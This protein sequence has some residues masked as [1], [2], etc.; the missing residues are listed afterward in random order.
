MQA[1]TIYPGDR[2]YVD[3]EGVI[4]Y[5]DG[6]DEP[7]LIVEGTMRDSQMKNVCQIQ[8]AHEPTEDQVSPADQKPAQE[9]WGGIHA[10]QH[11]EHDGQVTDGAV[12]FHDRSGWEDSSKNQ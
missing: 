11:V 1:V 3:G 10:S 9:A 6:F 5:R 12:N 7:W 8:S 4:H 2:V